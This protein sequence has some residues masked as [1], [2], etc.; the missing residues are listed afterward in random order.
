MGGLPFLPEGTEHPD[1]AS[2]RA[3]LTLLVQLDVAQLPNPQRHG[4]EGLLQLFHCMASPVC[5]DGWRPFARCH[6]GRRVPKAPGARSAVATAVQFPRWSVQR[7][8]PVDDYPDEED[9]E[10]TFGRPLDEAARAELEAVRATYPRA[11]DKLGGW[12]LWVQ[13]PERPPCPRCGR[14][15]EVLFQIESDELIPYTWGDLGIGHW[16]QCPA[17]PDVMTYSWAC[18]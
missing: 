18:T 8:V 7:W 2:C 12:P 15:M 11:G 5:E 14:T 17:H 16:T 10:D 1:C 6:L 13:G 9:L 4:G 3:P